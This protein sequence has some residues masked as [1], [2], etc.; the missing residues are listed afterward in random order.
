MHHEIGCRLKVSDL[1]KW[2][3][4]D[5]VSA[6]D[7]LHDS[8]PHSENIEAGHVIVGKILHRYVLGVNQQGLAR[9]ET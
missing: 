5:T 1:V 4:R 6:N 3:G 9:R 2:H 7:N 8:F